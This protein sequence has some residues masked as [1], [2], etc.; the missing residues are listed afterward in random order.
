M[1]TTLMLL[2]NPYRPDPRVQ[3]EARALRSIGMGVRLIAWDREGTFPS[4]EV[5]PE[6]EIV[7]VGPTS[8]T[9]SALK[10]ASRLPR[11]WLRALLASRKI[12]FDLVHAH[13]FD[14]LHLGLL[15][16]RLRNKKLVYDAHELYAKMIYAEAG[17][18][19]GLVWLMERRCVRRPDEVVTV[20]ESLATEL[21]KHRGTKVHVIT[22]SQD[23][24]D[25]LKGDRQSLRMKFGLKGFVISYLGAL[26]PG[27]FVE[28]L[29]TSFSQEDRVT[30]LVAGYGTL[31]Q[32]V[33]E[34]AK[35]NPAV[36]FIGRVD[37]DEALRLT[38]ASDL[39]LAMMDPSNPNNLVGTPGKIINSLAVGRP[40]ITAK[41]LQIADRIEKSGAGIVI[42]F[43]RSK[44]VEAVLKA[45]SDPNHLDEMGRNGRRLYE[46]EFSWEKSREKLV[47]VYKGLLR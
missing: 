35:S 47:S 32:K 20:S 17:P 23:P 22:T 4:H 34:A 12:E 24:S 16:A 33:A 36:R 26:E 9:R 46:Q 30:V 45:A 15:I 19:S 31:E 42:P 8:P 14:T 18:F 39:T 44:F 3:L 27:R 41:G 5:Q 13:D 28:E 2:S 7:R 6:L 43:D 25:V 37:S 40:V 1:P 11:F 21:D 10:V 38:W 29:V